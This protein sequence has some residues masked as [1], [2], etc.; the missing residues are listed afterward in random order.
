MF[1]QTAEVEVKDDWMQFGG[2]IQIEA[3]GAGGGAETTD[4][5]GGAGGY[6]RAFI[7]LDPEKLRKANNKLYVVVGKGGRE[8]GI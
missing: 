1:G 4:M 2:C 5:T 3:W 6:G 8:G 7:F